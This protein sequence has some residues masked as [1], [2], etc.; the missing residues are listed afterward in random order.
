MTVD[1]SAALSALA[2]TRIVHFTPVM[3]LLPI[4]RDGLLRSSKDLAENAPTQ[5]SPTDRA[6]YD[7]HPDY[8]CCSFEYP[9]AYYQDFASKKAE[10]ANY[11]AWVC[12]ILDIALVLRPGTLFSACN[13][14]KSYGAHLKEGG[15]ALLDC[16]ASPTA[17]ANVHRKPRHNPAVPTDLQT[18]VLIPGPI[19]LSAVSAIVTP[20]PEQAREQFGF[21]HRQKLNPSQ[22]EWRYAPLFYSR[23]DLRD[24]IWYNHSI[25]ETVW[26]PSPEDLA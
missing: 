9:N 12:L 20:S 11:P 15:Q 1:T 8:L 23:Y 5:F 16:W 25:P 4:F 10:F 14:A 22:V 6:R 26:M 13:A 7:A 17:P 21:L 3:N 2:V 24:A 18:E 19:P